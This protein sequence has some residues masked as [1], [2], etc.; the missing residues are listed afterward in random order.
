MKN[1]YLTERERY[2]IEV[3]LKTEDTCKRDRGNPRKVKVN[4][5][6]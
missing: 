6:S 1:K 4:Y 2:Q 3:L 5:I